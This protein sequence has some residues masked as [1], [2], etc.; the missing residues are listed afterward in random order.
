MCLRSVRQGRNVTQF[1]L[2]KSWLHDM[3]AKNVASIVASKGSSFFKAFSAVEFET[4]RIRHECEKEKRASG[5]RIS[6]NSNTP[7][8]DVISPYCL[9][10]ATMY[11]YYL[12]VV[13]STSLFQ[14]LRLTFLLSVCPSKKVGKKL[15][16]HLSRSETILLFWKI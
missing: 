16:R 2:K 6:K 12:A 9:S 15:K 10:P 5:W 11:L 4:L 7:L 8:L 13:S 14:P 3:S 1:P